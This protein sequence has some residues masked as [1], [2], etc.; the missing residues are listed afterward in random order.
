VRRATSQVVAYGYR[1]SGCVFGGWVGAPFRPCILY[2]VFCAYQKR[3]NV[4]EN[5]LVIV[6]GVSVHG[7]WLFA[8]RSWSGNEWNLTGPRR[9]LS[10]GW[11]IVGKSLVPLLEARSRGFS[12]RD[13]RCEIL[14]S[15]KKESG[16]PEDLMGHREEVTGTLGQNELC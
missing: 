14:L 2:F 15:F 12:S 13:S 6:F 10:F 7:K 5:P 1:G 3:T 8:F 11:L 16:Y 4:R 9:L